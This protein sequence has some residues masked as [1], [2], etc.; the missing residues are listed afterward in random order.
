MDD[1]WTSSVVSVLP[2]KPPAAFSINRPDHLTRSHGVAIVMLGLY[3]P[4]GGRG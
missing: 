4:A 2:V 3:E 1:D